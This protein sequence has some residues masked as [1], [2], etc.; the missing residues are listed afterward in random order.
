MSIKEGINLECTDYTTPTGFTVEVVDG[1]GEASFRMEFNCGDYGRKDLKAIMETFVGKYRNSF[2]P[3]TIKYTGLQIHD[4]DQETMLPTVHYEDICRHSS[5][6]VYNTGMEEF[7]TKALRGLPL[8]YRLFDLLQKCADWI[9]DEDDEDI[10]I[11]SPIFPL[12]VDEEL[13][14]K[15]L[16]RHTMP[17][18][19]ERRILQVKHDLL[20][21]YI[22]ESCLYEEE[23][24]ALRECCDHKEIVVSRREG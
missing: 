24:E 23:L 2:H 12:D 17:G 19:N 20:G 18:W 11:G 14:K 10:M 3:F 15:W 5:A 21:F 8:R 1:Y 16:E 4:I 22:E 6:S 7:I 13:E 9:E